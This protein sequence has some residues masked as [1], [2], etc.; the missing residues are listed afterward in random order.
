METPAFSCGYR[1]AKWWTA[2]PPQQNPTAATCLAPHFSFRY[3][4]TASTS[5]FILVAFLSF[6]QS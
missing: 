3:F 5:L 6:N 4:N 1:R 2:V